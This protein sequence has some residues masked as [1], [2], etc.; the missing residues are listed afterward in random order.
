MATRVGQDIRHLDYPV[1][2]QPASIWFHYIN[3]H[4]ISGNLMSPGNHITWF[5]PLNQGFAWY[6]V[7]RFWGEKW[8][9]WKK[10]DFDNR[11]S[12]NILAKRKNAKIYFLL[13]WLIK[14]MFHE[15][16]SKREVKT[17]STFIFSI[18]LKLLYFLKRLSKK[19]K[20]IGRITRPKNLLNTQKLNFAIK[21]GKGYS[22]VKLNRL[23]YYSTFFYY[24]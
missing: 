23:K 24:F 15:M 20:K 3:L 19:T 7:I 17:F 18:F 6:M 10:D 4:R 5:L 12:R 16:S 11:W 13:I 8:K 14:K 2:V 1:R 9:I 22:F 21:R